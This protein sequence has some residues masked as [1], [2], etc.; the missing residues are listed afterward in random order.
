MATALFITEQYIKDNSVIDENVDM[1]YITTTIDKCQKKY[2]R[3]ILG[4]AL[5][6]ELQTQVNAGTETA[7]NI[8]LLDD[9]ISDCLMYYVLTEGINIFAYKITN[10]SILKKNGESSQVADTDELATLRDGYKDDGEFFAEL[11]TKY[12]LANTESYPL[13]LNPGNDYDTVHPNYDNFTTGWALGNRRKGSINIEV[14]RSR[15]K[16]WK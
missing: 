7:L 2:I 5:F 16:P 8:T 11:I 6:D 9:Y 14:A 10:K 1:H 3:P 4:S 15:Y 12:L 13:F